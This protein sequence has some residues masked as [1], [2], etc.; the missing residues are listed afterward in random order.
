MVNAFEERNKK[1]DKGKQILHR[2]AMA[3]LELN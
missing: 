1:R 2:R 3:Q